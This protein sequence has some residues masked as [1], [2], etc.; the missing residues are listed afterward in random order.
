M[1]RVTAILILLAMLISP[2][3]VTGS[4]GAIHAQSDT[5]RIICQSIGTGLGGQDCR[6]ADE[7]TVIGL[8][9]TAIGIISFFIGAIAVIV[10]IVAAFM[11]VTSAGNPDTTKKAK[12]AI[13]Y[14]FVAI[15]VAVFAR[16]IVGFIISSV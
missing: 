9:N 3:L 6:S 2:M 10:I 16:V 14:S 5:Q 13:I 8:A 11:Y 7:G 12:N 4:I 1:K 15:T